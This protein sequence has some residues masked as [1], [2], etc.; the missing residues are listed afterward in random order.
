MS[1]LAV[2]PNSPEYQAKLDQSIEQIINHPLLEKD[3]LVKNGFKTDLQ[4]F[5]AE[6][7]K[8]DIQLEA[9][10]AHILASFKDSGFYSNAPQKQ[11][12]VIDKLAD[13]FL[14]QAKTQMAAGQPLDRTTKEQAQQAH[15]AQETAALKGSTGPS[16]QSAQGAQFARKGEKS[17]EPSVQGAEPSVQGQDIEN[18]A[19]A[20]HAV[21]S[22]VANEMAQQRAQQNGGMPQQGGGKTVTAGA[23]MMSAFIER[24]SRNKNTEPG[25]TSQLAENIRNVATL[26]DAELVDRPLVNGGLGGKQ[27]PQVEFTDKA[28]S[29]LSNLKESAK[30]VITLGEASD[31]KADEG[32]RNYA[33]ALDEH[34]AALG[35]ENRAIMTKVANGEMTEEEAAEHLNERSKALGETHDEVKNSPVGKG[36]KHKNFMDA[37]DER[38]K[39]LQESIKEMLESLRKGLSSIANMFRQNNSAPGPKP[40]G[41]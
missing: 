15:V 35:D 17:A 5:I 22:A 16:T 18:P 3:P 25:P 26:G 41:H 9:N 21:R 7:S 30:Q 4:H 39:S 27:A 23:V 40:P 31:P 8:K 36:E 34:G 14:N 2:K 12:Q 10:P 11:Q 32:L 19:N 24:F 20:H 28:N 38:V 1:N 13:D 29:T 6:A 33:S 37:A